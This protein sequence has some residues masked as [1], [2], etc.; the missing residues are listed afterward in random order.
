MISLGNSKTFFNGKKI[1]C[2]PPILH[3]DK[4]AIDFQVKCES[5][6]SHFAKQCSL[7]KNESRTPP[8]L[9]PHL[10]TF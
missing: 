1:P 2:I 9:L 6:N 10:N 4:F 3:E 7:L 8:Q 5:F